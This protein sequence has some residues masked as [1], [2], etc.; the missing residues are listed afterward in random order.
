M[1]PRIREVLAH[2]DY[3]LTLTFSTGETRDFDL[4]PYLGYPVFEPL[5]DIGFF[6]L[7]RAAHGTVVWPKDI[8]FDPD[9]LFLESRMIDSRHA[10]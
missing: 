8:D 2:D 1:N 9:T 3:T 5:Q 4:K 7:A 6:K 10:A